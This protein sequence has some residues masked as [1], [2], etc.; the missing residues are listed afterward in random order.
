MHI[1]NGVGFDEAN[2]KDIRLTAGILG[3]SSA[4]AK[5]IVDLE[6]RR[7]AGEDAVIYKRG[8]V[9]LVGPRIEP[10]EKDDG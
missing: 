2:E 4:S 3:N 7:A 8:S 1:I 6:A 10:T 9:L 5:A